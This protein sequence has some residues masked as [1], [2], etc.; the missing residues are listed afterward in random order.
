MSSVWVNFTTKSAGRKIVPAI[1]IY[2]IDE[3]LVVNIIRKDFLKMVVI[4]HNIIKIDQ[5]F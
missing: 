4:I 1:L 5:I 2:L 3:E